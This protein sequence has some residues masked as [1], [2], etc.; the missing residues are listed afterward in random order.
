MPDPISETGSGA[1]ETRKFLPLTEDDARRLFR[2]API[3]AFFC[4]P[5]RLIGVNRAL[6]EMFGWESTD[7]LCEDRGFCADFLGRCGFAASHLPQPGERDAAIC[8]QVEFQ[9]KEGSAL[10]ARLT[11]LPVR[12]ATGMLRWY[13]GFVE[14]LTELERVRGEL[15]EAQELGMRGQLAS[16][17]A[18]DFNN[19][20]SGALIHLGL[21]LQ[22]S[23]VPAVHHEGLEAMRAEMTRAADLTRQILS[24]SR[25]HAVAALG[26]LE[27]NRQIGELV[28]ILRRLTR[29]NI[30]VV[31]LPAR[32][33]CWIEADAGLIEMLVMHLCLLSRREMPQ[34]GTLTLSTHLVSEG[35]SAGG[36]KV[37]VTVTQSKPAAQRA[38]GRSG[39][40]VAAWMA[41]KDDS[42]LRAIREIIDLHHGRLELPDFAAGQAQYRLSL[43][44]ARQSTSRANEDASE[45]ITGGGETV[46]LIEDERYL[47]H[48]S[49]LCL[50]KLGYAVIEAGDDEEALKLW[51]RHQ[52]KIDVVFTDFLLPGFSTGLDLARLMEKE[53]PSVKII[54]TSGTGADFEE[55]LEAGGAGVGHLSKPYTKAELARALRRCL[56]GPALPQNQAHP[57]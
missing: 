2:D 21:L 56:D 25:R 46:L 17:I 52:Q 44:R 4:T 5:E 35:A 26:A 49:T 8:R 7:A 31:F 55:A 43:P 38:V 20:L 24:L 57:S 33:E 53:K 45:E 27:I 12:S 14:D 9:H 54:V 18:H 16:G 32:E 51:A 29:E 37:C 39:A 11:L 34:G 48:A 3:G 50:R 40:L 30:L 15:R 23:A 1:R 41:K 19:I 13:E 28:P 10:A 47:R 6:A 22:D 42:S 36:A